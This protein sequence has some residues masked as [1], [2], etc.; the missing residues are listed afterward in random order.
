MN[1]NCWADQDD[2]LEGGLLFISSVLPGKQ[3]NPL[4]KK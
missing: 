3:M 1:F 2:D 4:Y